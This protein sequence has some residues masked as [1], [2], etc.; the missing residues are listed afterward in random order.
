[1]LGT[2]GAGTPR[3]RAATSC[4]AALANGGKTLA[5]S[6]PEVSEAIDFVE[7]YR[8]IGALVLRGLPTRR[9]AR[10]SGVVVVVLAVEF[11]HRH[12]VRRRRRGAGRRQHA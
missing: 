4:G 5:E 8:G 7:F 3:R 2:R 6:D 11:S 12:S 10:P 1:M 9:S